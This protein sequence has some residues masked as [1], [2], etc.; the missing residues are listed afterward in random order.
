[1]KN[2]IALNLLYI[3]TLSDCD[4]GWIICNGTVKDELDTL[5][6]NGNKKEVSLNRKSSLWSVIK[7]F[8]FNVQYTEVARKLPSYGCITFSNAIVDYPNERERAFIII[9]NK[10]LSIRTNLGS[11][12]QETKFKVTRMRCWRVTTNYDVR[13]WIF[14]SYTKNVIVILLQTCRTKISQRIAK[15]VRA[16]VPIIPL[17][18]IWNCPLNI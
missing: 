12:F 7:K 4:R 14:F 10:E 16:T 3:L 13:V 5:K 18:T 2:S 6:A 17:F 11:K 9:G 15:A 1:M 8:V